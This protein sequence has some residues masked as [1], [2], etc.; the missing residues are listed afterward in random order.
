MDDQRTD[1]ASGGSVSAGDLLGIW[2]TPDSGGPSDEVLVLK[3]DGSGAIDFYNYAFA[4]RDEFRWEIIDAGT[5]IRFS[6]PPT[7]WSAE[8]RRIAIFRDKNGTRVLRLD[9]NYDFYFSEM[10]L[11]DYK[12][13]KE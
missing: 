4:G 11:S 7:C 9:E 13:P 6:S 3:S 12:P 1:P 10:S 8:P 2:I 5:K